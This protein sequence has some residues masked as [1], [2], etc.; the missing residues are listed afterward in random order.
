MTAI[1][2]SCTTIVCLAL[3]SSAG[4][5]G[6]VGDGFVE[7]TSET[8]DTEVPE[9]FP[10]AGL[11]PGGDPAFQSFLAEAEQLV[12]AVNSPG[13][14]LAIVCGGKIAHVAGIGTVKAGGPAITA[15][16][17][18]QLASSTK[19]FTAAA[20]ARLDAQGVV[21]LDAPISDYIPN[22]QFGHITLRELLSHSSGIPG[23]LDSYQSATLEGLVRANESMQLWA[24][25][26]AVWNYSNTGYLVAGAVLE[27]ATG[28]AFSAI[29]KNHVFA[30]AG[31]TG[32]TMATSD[33]LAA[34]NYAY[35]HEGT[36]TFGP[37][38]SYYGSAE[39]G[40]MGGAWSSARDMG[41]WAEAHFN[42][43]DPLGAE[44]MPSL[45][46]QA[47]RTG[48]TGQGY[49]LGLFVEDSSPVM[50][51]HGGNVEGF[52]ASFTMVPASG[53]AVVVLSHGGGGFG[54]GAVALNPDAIAN[55]AL[56][57][58]VPELRY[59]TPQSPATHAELVGTYSSAPSVFGEVIIRETG[60]GLEAE[61]VDKGIT[62][63]LTL[64][65]GDAYGVDLPPD[66]EI[67]ITFWR[68]P[69]QSASHIVSRFGVAAR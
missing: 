42:S 46:H 7:P 69:G 44:V 63:P 66:G 54:G 47:I 41:L 11:C 62:R 9:E 40:P 45:R 48:S 57:A 56:D 36:T 10:N 30:P 65:Y 31:M 15:D 16:T 60:G 35:G 64:W 14:G 55:L 49:G 28:E 27:A 12:D 19:M 58:Y 24:Q 2:Y 68:D 52:T 59:G 20:A 17:H 1:R 29:I 8:D 4:C 6:M 43:D 39:Y 33:V 61:F 32:A 38:D 3:A 26:G 25:P 51:H 13:V 23:E 37:N 53:F 18:F 21:N 5:M 22:L 34:G 50:L 67:D